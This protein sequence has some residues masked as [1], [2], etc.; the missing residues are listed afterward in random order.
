MILETTVK[1]TGYEFDASKAVIRAWIVTT[2][3]NPLISILS[4]LE[5][6]LRIKLLGYL[7]LQLHKVKTNIYPSALELALDSSLSEEM[8]RYLVRISS[9]FTKA[10]ENIFFDLEDF[11]DET[12]SPQRK[13]GTR[14]ARLES[15]VG[16][17]KPVDL[18]LG[19][20]KP[21][22]RRVEARTSTDVGRMVL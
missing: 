18:C 8:L 7:H 12:D 20:V 6:E 22:G 11:V 19:R 1:L 15:I 14:C 16:Y 5:G 3:I 4:S 13:R 9:A 21:F 10:L 17:P 2:D